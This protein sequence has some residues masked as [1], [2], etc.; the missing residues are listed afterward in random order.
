[1]QS[2]PPGSYLQLPMKN[3]WGGIGQYAVSAPSKHGRFVANWGNAQTTFGFADAA[4]LCWQV[5]GGGYDHHHREPFNARL[6]SFASGLA[7]GLLHLQFADRRRLVAKHAAYKV[8]ERLRWPD[9]PVR[10]IDALYNLAVKPH[11]VQVAAAPAEWL[12]PYADIL[13]HLDLGSEPWQERWVR[14]QVELHGAEKFAGLDLF[15]LEGEQ[16]QPV[17]AATS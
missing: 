12:A 14:E 1:M 5:Q 7:G 13:H 9:K 16:C 11:A 8:T 15:G 6:G 10:D 4:R 17:L 2:L 3:M